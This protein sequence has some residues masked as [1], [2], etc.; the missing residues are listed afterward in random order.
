VGQLDHSIINEASGLAVSSF[1]D[2]LYHINDSG[3]G[4]YFYQTDL[5]GKNTKKIEIENF[6]PVDV[7]DLAYG[8][9]L[10]NKNC[11]F[12]G[13][14]GDNSEAR[15]TIS[16]VVIEDKD[17]FAD[18]VTPLKILELKYPERAHNAEGMALHPNGDLYILTKEVDYPNQRAVSAIL[19]KLTKEKM[20]QK[21]NETLELEKV[22]EYEFPFILFNF[23]LW[24]RIVTAFDISSD[25]KR[26]L[27][28]TYKTAIEISV[29]LDAGPMKPIREMVPGID[30]QI[31]PIPAL[32][33]QEAIAFSQDGKSFFYNTEFKENKADLIKVTCS[34]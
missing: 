1:E 31:I 4:P 33:Q 9:C 25:G 13:D 19:F 34:E 16:V 15:K 12:I 3:D 14:I 5:T 23:N 30:H 11:L 22:F 32:G 17:V 27:V 29:D 28:L 20:A 21:G 10:D 8:N 18:K 26:L 24:G 6:V 7:E 2:R